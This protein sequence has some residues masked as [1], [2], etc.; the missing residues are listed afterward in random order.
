MFER[1]DLD[2]ALSI[3]Q[4]ARRVCCI[5]HRNPDGDAIGS[6]TGV[7]LLLAEHVPDVPAE[8]YCVDP[9]PPTFH[10]LPSAHRIRTDLQPKEGDAFVFVDCAEPHLTEM[11]E[12]FPELFDRTTYPSVQF[13]HHGSNSKFAQVNFVFAD[14]ASTCEIVLAFA[15]EAG[16][17]VSSEAATCLLTGVYTDTG[18]LL[19]SNTT[20]RV[21]RTVARLLRCGARHQTIV[22]DV[23]RTAKPSTLRLWGR[24]LEKISITEE[25]AAISGLTEGD[26][27]ATGAEYSELTGAIDYVNAVPGMKFSLIL[28]EREGKVKGSLRTMRDDVDVSAL[29]AK[30]KG[31][32]HKKAAGFALPG[33]LKS[34]TRWKVE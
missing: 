24:V 25:G 26:F 13:D 15:D 32:G 31:G 9:P 30:F 11:H 29:A 16:W 22:K 10:F 2:R 19:H 7:S 20:S 8:T 3:F 33:K 34:E 28:A 4:S 18:G 12:R 21:Y 27:R 5:C 23:F 1:A 17:H 14:A 6:V